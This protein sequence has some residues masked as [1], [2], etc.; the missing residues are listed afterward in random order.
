[1]AAVAAI[2]IPGRFIVEVLLLIRFKADGV[3][4]GIVGGHDGGDKWALRKGGKEERVHFVPF[5]VSTVN[6]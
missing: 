1:M 2:R 3:G 5:C 4:G 6:C